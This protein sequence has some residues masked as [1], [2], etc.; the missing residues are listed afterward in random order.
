METKYYSCKNKTSLIKAFK[1]VADLT[2]LQN[3][4]DW[5]ISIDI[6]GVVDMNESHVNTIDEDGNITGTEQEPV[7]SDY[8]F[9]VKFLSEKYKPLFKN[10]TEETPATPLRTF[11]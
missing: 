7:W 2:D 4:D 6:I 8:L 3:Y 10:F 9:N 11:A 1:S 5:Y